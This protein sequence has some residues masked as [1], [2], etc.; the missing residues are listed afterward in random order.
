M[1][2]VDFSLQIKDP[3]YVMKYVE[4]YIELSFDLR[5]GEPVMETAVSD[6]KHVNSKT[7]TPIGSKR[8]LP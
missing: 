4:V 8:E 1:L 2:L 5:P 6:K 7:S 3:S